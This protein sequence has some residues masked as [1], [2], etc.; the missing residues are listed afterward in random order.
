MPLM[1]AKIQPIADSDQEVTISL[2]SI[3]YSFTIPSRGLPTFN[4][5]TRSEHEDPTPI[6]P[7]VGHVGLAPNLPPALSTNTQPTTPELN[8]NSPFLD[9]ITTPPSIQSLRADFSHYFHLFDGVM[10]DLHAHMENFDLNCTPNSFSFQQEH[11]IIKN[12][13]QSCLHWY[14]HM[15]NAALPLAKQQEAQLLHF[16]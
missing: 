13:V 9:N 8:S 3:N 11:Q 6:N 5:Y 15:I 4:L 7:L 16:R 10:N 1:Y 12:S 14:R 2:D